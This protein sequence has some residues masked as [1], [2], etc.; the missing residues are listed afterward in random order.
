MRI[1]NHVRARETE[2]ERGRVKGKEWRDNK[3]GK[4]REIMK[5]RERKVWNTRKR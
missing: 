1:Y 2:R 5:E 4:V 3:R